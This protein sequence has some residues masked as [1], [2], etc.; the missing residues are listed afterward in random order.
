MNSKSTQNE[1]NLATLLLLNGK[2]NN[3]T[4]KKENFSL[5][6]YLSIQRNANELNN[7]KL[8]H[9]SK[10]I[11]FNYNVDRKSISINNYRSR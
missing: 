9:D 3:Q 1:H 5:I 8:Y 11:I 10:L 2:P 6:V 7:K 4:K